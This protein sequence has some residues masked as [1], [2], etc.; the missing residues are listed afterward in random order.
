MILAT[1]TRETLTTTEQLDCDT[2]ARFAQFQR[3]TIED[4]ETHTCNMD[5]SV[6]AHAIIHYQVAR[7]STEAEWVDVWRRVR[8]LPR[9]LA[10]QE[11]LLTIGK[12]RKKTPDR[13]I[14]AF[15]TQH[16]LPAIAKFFATS[17]ADL[18]GQRGRNSFG[19]ADEPSVL[20]AKAEAVIHTAHEELKRVGHAL[21]VAGTGETN[22]KRAVMHATSETLRAME[23]DRPHDD[24]VLTVYQE[25]L[26]RLR[27]YPS[28]PHA[29]Q[30]MRAQARW[31]MAR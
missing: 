2:M 30:V 7:A 21:G 22:S 26:V 9:A 1:G 12:Q 16:Q 3:H 29:F 24:E 20:I 14:A 17:L 10:Q 11:S 27:T 13:T 5:A 4:L 23:G 6:Y 25:L 19:I 31:S 15:V 28:R 8:E 18:P